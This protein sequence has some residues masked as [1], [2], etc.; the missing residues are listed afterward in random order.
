MEITMDTKAAELWAAQQKAEELFRQ[1]SLRNLIRPGILESA[2]NAEIFELANELYG[3]KKYWHKRIVRAGPNTL[4][5]YAENPPD[6][7]IAE[8]DIVFLDLGPVFEDWEADFGR[9][10]VLGDDPA[11]NK[12]RVDAETAF[13]K[14]KEHF[15]ATAGITASELFNYIVQLAEESGWEFGGVIAGH[16]VGQFPHERIDGDK[17]SLYIHPKNDTP[18]RQ[19][20]SDGAIRH[21]ILEIHFVDRQRQIGA[22]FE[23]LLT[24]AA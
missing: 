22:F 16:L 5:P 3:I 11:K 8:D 17:V 4:S 7:L 10:Y 21:W 12:L 2:L 14:G 15:Q 6:R 9:T 19:L 24:V 1:I 18:I 20:G 13:A 23:E